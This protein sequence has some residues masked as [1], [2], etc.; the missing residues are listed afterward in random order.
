MSLANAVP[1][2]EGMGEDEF[3][4]SLCLQLLHEPISVMCCG[5][6]FCKSCLRSSLR[7]SQACP[8]CRKPCYLN[9][10][11]ATPSRLLVGLLAHRF[12]AAVAERAR[13]A[14]EDEATSTRLPLFLMGSRAHFVPFPGAPVALHL[15]EPRYVMMAEQCA[16][17]DSLF[18]MQNEATDT[19]G[20]AVEITRMELLPGRRVL[21]RGKCK[22]RY[23]LLAPADQAE[24]EHG[25]YRGLADLVSD[26]A[27]AGPAAA[28]TFE[29][30]P[31]SQAARGAL[32]RMGSAAEQASHVR[33]C[34]AEVLSRVL[35]GLSP[36]A[37]RALESRHG[38]M[39]PGAG[40]AGSPERWSYYAADVLAMPDDAKTACFITVSTVQRL[41]RCYCFLEG[42]AAELRA[43]GR[44]GATSGPASEAAS[45]GPSALGEAQPTAEAGVARVPASADASAAAG[46]DT[47]PDVITPAVANELL[48]MLVPSLPVSV[49]GVQALRHAIGD[50]IGFVTHVLR[51]PAVSSLAVF[52]A[53]LALLVLLRKPPP[54]PHM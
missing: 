53:V 24:G 17:H 25:L 37:L 9:V 45:D 31:L 35:A 12:P 52:A 51:H 48:Q 2:L 3:T 54:I 50:P 14:A 7:I 28:E 23:R 18:G 11:D 20:V 13:Q 4:C 29:D 22:Q 10:R 38:S 40:P 26:G 44:T 33:S 5:N 30:T 41:V 21:L 32:R 34:V 16:E 36:E 8:L 42:K 6:S 47:F 43:R 19:W 15:F 27:G 49:L 39:P 46:L 1:A